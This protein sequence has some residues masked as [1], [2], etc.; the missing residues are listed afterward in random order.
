MTHYWFTHISLYNFLSIIVSPGDKTVYYETQSKVA[1][2]LAFLIKNK[3]LFIKYDFQLDVKDNS[4]NALFYKVEKTTALLSDVFLESHNAKKIINYY[5]QNYSVEWKKILKSALIY[6]Y[7]KKIMYLLFIDN[8]YRK[9]D[10]NYKKIIIYTNDLPKNL[11]KNYLK[12]V[13]LVR[14]TEIKR[15][16]TL[17]YFFSIYPFPGRLIKFLFKEFYGKV[18]KSGNHKIPKKA[19]EKG[20]II[21][22]Y[23]T[24]TLKIYPDRGHLFWFPNSNIDPERVILYFQGKEITPTY[25]NLSEIDSYNFSWMDL[26]FQSPH[27]TNLYTMVKKTFTKVHTFTFIMHEE[28]FW[29]YQHFLLYDLKLSYMRQII[30]KFNVKAIHQFEEWTP[31]TIIK[32]IALK[33]E[34]GIMIWNHWSVD[35][36]PV[37]W[38]DCGVADLVFSW[39]RLNDGYFNAHNFSYKYLVQTGIV[40]GDYFSRKDLKQVEKIK[41]KFNESVNTIITIFD[42]TYGKY[43]YHSEESMRNFYIRILKYVLKYNEIGIIIKPKGHYFKNLKKSKFIEKSINELKSNGRCII[44]DGILTKPSIAALCANICFSYGIN[45]VGVFSSLNGVKSLHFELS[46]NK[47]HPFYY[48][49]LEGKVIIN[50]LDFFKSFNH[51]QLN[52]YGEHGPCLKLIDSFQDWNGN[53]RAGEL[54]GDYIKFCDNGFNKATSLDKAISNYRERWG[55]DKV[56][57][58]I[59]CQNHIGNDLWK[60]V[61]I[62]I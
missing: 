45:T 31:E 42:S 32:S 60:K 17:K 9:N 53:Y 35:R 8:H 38:T 18:F 54:I 10:F 15:E 2:Y 14:N 37:S 1:K 7:R 25:E 51:K 21:E 23:H 46:G 27:V 56:S 19:I 6:N 11:I 16:I 4:G 34:G 33:M 30:R 44:L 50:S 49:G 29:L 12:R 22:Q 39:G 55:D 5:Y 26:N 41:S 48:L 13:H 57:S 36:F 28:N 61:F 43:V 58:K 40:A 24:D 47:E 20:C 52:N 62:N 59:N 3:I